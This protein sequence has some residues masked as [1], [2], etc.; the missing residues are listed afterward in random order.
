MPFHLSNP[1]IQTVLLK[2]IFSSSVHDICMFSIPFL[3][4]K[5]VLERTIKCMS[6]EWKER[7]AKLKH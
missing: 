2:T 7:K 4:Y 3:N 1:F 5:K 6:K